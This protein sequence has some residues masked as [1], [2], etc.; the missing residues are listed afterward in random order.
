MEKYFTELFNNLPPEELE[1]YHK[2]VFLNMDGEFAALKRYEYYQDKMKFMGKNVKI[3]CGVK[4]VNPQYISLGDNVLIR[5]HCA[6]ICNSPKGITLE[7]NAKLNHGVYLD[8]ELPDTGYIRI[9]KRVYIGTGCCLHGHNGLEIGD[10]SLLAQNITIT[11][12]SHKFD[13]ITKTIYSQ[14]G[15]SRKIVIGKD[16]Y[17]G[18][19]VCVVYS[20]DIGDGSVI[21]A[22]SVV[23]KTIP[24]FSVAVGV[25]AKVIRKRGEPIKKKEQ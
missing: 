14:G 11:P 19:N 6:L 8:T 5:D 20:A 1:N 23:V 16:C 12:W 25:P 9:G 2:T 22:G 15:H 21:G 18:K 3:G 24:P 4:F 13:D 17:I 7:E 10:D